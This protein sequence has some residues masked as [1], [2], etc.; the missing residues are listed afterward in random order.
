LGPGRFAQLK[1]ISFD[2]GP[3]ASASIGQ[4]YCGFIGDR[5]VAVKCQRPN[6][7]AEIAL[8]LHLVR[9][10]APLYQKITSSATDYQSLANEW[11]RGFIAE[12]DY[13]EEAENTILFNK[14]MQM[15]KMNAVI[16]PTV[17]EEFSTERILVTEW[18]QGV[19]LDQSLAD[20]VPRLCSVALNAYLV[21][22]LET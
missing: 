22:L 16:A 1:E 19:R 2:K 15:R 18:V 13:R 11:G 21:M 20:D 4:V 3:V 5:E 10:F 7:L 9:E 8:D 17:V 6:A 12:L 14:D